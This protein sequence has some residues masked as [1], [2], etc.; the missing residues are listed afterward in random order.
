MGMGCSI[1][2]CVGLPVGF[3][4]LVYVV[5]V[6]LA[7]QNLISYSVVDC[8]SGQVDS[9]DGRCSAE[10]SGATAGHI[11]HLG[12]QCLRRLF[13]GET[14][15]IVMSDADRDG[16][17]TSDMQDGRWLRL[18]TMPPARIPSRP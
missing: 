5:N 6:S 11:G 7:L 14:I 15:E 10:E 12:C 13:I 16:V 18:T 9:P 3:V 2:C 1:C 4:V 17:S 8:R